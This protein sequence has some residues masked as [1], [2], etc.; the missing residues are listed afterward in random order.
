MKTNDV[1]EAGSNRDAYQ[2]DYDSSVSGMGRPADHRGL[3]QELA[4]ETNNIAVYI[5]GKLWKVW[6]GKGTA[7]S[8]EERAYL[9]SMQGW[10]DKKS[11]ATGKKWTVGLT[12]ANVSE[13]TSAAVRMQRAA[14]KQRA[15]SDASLARTPS[16]I[17]KKEE[18]K[19]P[20]DQKGVAEAGYPEVDHMPGPTIKRTQ[21]GC[22]RCHGK[23]YVY[24]TPDGEV[25]PTNQS[26][27]KKYKC[28][29]C[30]GIGF[31][32]TEGVAEAE[33]NPHT[34][35]L[36]KALYRDLSKEKKA[37]PAQVEKNKANWAKNPHNPANKE[38]GVAEGSQRVDSLVTDALKIMRGAEVGDAVLA[39]KTVLGDREYNGRRGFYNFYVKQMIDMYGQQ[40]VSESDETN[41]KDK[42]CV[43]V[44]LFIRLMEYAR[45]D[46]ATDMD[47]HSLAER[48][49]A[50]SANG[51]T[52]GM[53]SYDAVVGN[54]TP[55]EEASLAQMR[56]YFT[57]NDSNTVELDNKY[58]TPERSRQQHVPPEIQSLINKM[59][60]VG[61]I[62]PKEFDI[63]K[64]F[65]L[66][67]KINVGL[68]IKEADK[69]PYAIGMAQAMKSTGD[70][71]P[72]KKST[73]N[74][75]H[76]IAKK[77]KEE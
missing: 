7:D 1:N 47:L 68:N 20:I 15:K 46:A 12:G 33:K 9:N 36:G 8:R 34:S 35:A 32:K 11:A 73:I 51:E 21:T 59:Y 49:T 58:G 2:R 48:L 4:H 67:T 42:I 71:P 50:M 76:E 72:L 27:A 17:P 63:L 41:P 52:L 3:R 54:E 31:V 37:S 40:G 26:D 16:S 66:K 56:D 77:I 64:N 5:N 62:T 14:D 69:N 55:V 53:D 24:K 23:G 13:A 29:K 70:N 45:E 18:P 39:L 57:Q 60:R 19:Q 61:K 22:K 75:A 6:A 38:Q 28:G 10:A 74:K 25:H 65:Q 30:N 43:D 44:P